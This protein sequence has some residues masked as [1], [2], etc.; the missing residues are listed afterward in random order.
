M[1]HY[2]VRAYPDHDRLPELID[3]L[4]DGQVREL[5]PFGRE[6]DRALRRARIDPESGQAVWE[7]EDH[8]SP[9]LAMEREAVLEAHFDEIEVEEVEPGEGWA[10]IEAL[11]SLWPRWTTLADEL[12]G[13]GGS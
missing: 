3:R 11:P 6:L 2:L 7:E 8:C 4:Q 13:P 12:P 1:T 10:R 9:P 5:E